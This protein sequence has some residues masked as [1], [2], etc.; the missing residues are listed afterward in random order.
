[1]P[2]PILMPDPNPNL[3]QSF[4]RVAPLRASR[5][6]ILCLG[7]QSSS[8]SVCPN[9]NFN[10]QSFARVAPILCIPET[11]VS[12]RHTGFRRRNTRSQHMLW[13]W[14]KQRV[15]VAPNTA[16]CDVGLEETGVNNRLRRINGLY[17]ELA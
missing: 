16:C 14:T 3:S 1:M 6:H 9:P 8:S 11:Y 17:L 7:E 2:A 15:F 4:A 13:T 10:P 12:R 5:R